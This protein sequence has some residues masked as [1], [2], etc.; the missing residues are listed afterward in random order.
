[1]EMV[2]AAGLDLEG[3][4]A[5]ERI[6]G[7]GEIVLLHEGL[8]SLA[9]WRDFPVALSAATGRAVFAYTRQGYGRST[10]LNGPRAPDYLHVE[11][12]EVLPAVLA[13][14][15]ISRP[16]LFGHS[17]GATIAL[18]FAAAFPAALAGLALEAPH[19]F[20]EDLTIAGIRAADGVFRTTDLPRKLARYHPDPEAVFGAWRDIWLDPAF[21]DWNIEVGLG[22]ITCPAVLIQGEDDEYGTRAQIDA[23][24]ARL[25]R[26]E[27]LMLPRC[28]HAPHRDR[29]QAVLA[30]TA[31]FVSRLG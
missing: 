30:A 23:I 4:W 25:A 22:A 12:L 28:G 10:P 9:Q 6:A 8:G 21:R 26:S 31:A 7:R 29:M 24:A 1:M 18:L 15:A 11:A 27:T 2:R 20:G 5:G 17:D 3:A 19:V 14:E 13:V 16:M